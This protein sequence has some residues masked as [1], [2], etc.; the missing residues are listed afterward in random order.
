MTDQ[1]EAEFKLRARS[2]IEVV[3]VDAALRALDAD[4]RLSVS[5][6][7]TDTYFDDAAG[8][9]LRAG[10][11]LRLREHDAGRAVTCKLRRTLEGCL[12]VRREL[13]SPWRR[14]ELPRLADE[15][16]EALRDVVQPLVLGRAL[17]PRQRL[18]VQRD[19]RVLSRSGADVC[20]LAIDAVTA[21]ANGRAATF[22]ELELEV[23]GDA[24]ASERLAHQLRVALPV[25]FAADDKPTH[26]AALLGLEAPPPPVCRSGGALDP[27]RLAGEA[28]PQQVLEGIDEIRRREV[29]VRGGDAPDELRRMR[30]AIRRTRTVVRAF[31]ALWPEEVAGRL[32]AH[33]GETGRRLGPVRE[34]DVLLSTLPADLDLLPAQLQPAGRRACEWI[35]ERRAAAHQ[36]A[37]AWLRSAER[38]EAS[39]RLDRDAA[40]IDARSPIAATP[41][42]ALAP[43]MLSRAVARL[44]K[45]VRQLPE[46]GPT[47][48]LHEVR[49]TAK[50]A[51]Y[52]AERFGELPGTDLRAGLRAIQRVQ[53]RLGAV[54]DREG[55]AERLL[56]WVDAA[57]AEGRDGAWT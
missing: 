24:A 28:V 2:P 26:A 36:L 48:A 43:E 56:G 33:L 54:C 7:H 41:L 1:I 18:V 14:D 23:I 22:Q 11:G 34:F 16:P 32:L 46:D 47:S 35:T 12:H 6:R 20:E 10:V 55:A 25:E 19:V 4:C 42:R 52:L 15:L 17:Q 51:R 57:A 9:L 49:L 30:V 37:L 40:A 39:D 27:T 38:L 50:R 44:K 8:S 45:Q 3:A 53:R 5:R 21:H 31:R 13:E 29:P